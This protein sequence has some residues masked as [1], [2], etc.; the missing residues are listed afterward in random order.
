MST[1]DCSN[2]KASVSPAAAS[3]CDP[4][5]FYLYEFR[6]RTGYA[7][8]I[9]VVERLREVAPNLAGLKVSDQPFAD[10]EPYL[11]EGLDVFIGAESL[12]LEGLE[13]GAAARIDFAS[14]SGLR[15]TTLESRV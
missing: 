3:A 15:N 13:R 2:S 1:T 6:A 11:I 4:V 7:I 10:V 12:L 9:P 5:P 8:P 14:E